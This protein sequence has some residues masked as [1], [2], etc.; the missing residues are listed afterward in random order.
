METIIVREGGLDTEPQVSKDE[1]KQILLDEDFMSN[2]YKFALS[3]FFLEPDHK[4]TCKYISEK[5]HVSPSSLN[6]LITQFSAKVE[7]K[8]NRFKIVKED[9]A[10]NWWPITMTGRRLSGGLFEWKLRQELVDAMLELDYI[11]SNAITI[12]NL[13]S[14]VELL[15]IDLRE[16]INTFRKTRKVLSDKER[17]TSAGILFKVSD[18]QADWAINESEHNEIQY[19]LFLKDNQIGY[20]LGFNAQYVPSSNEKNSLELVKPFIDAFLSLQDSEEVK[21]LKD[22]GFEVDLTALKNMRDGQYILFGRVVSLI[23]DK[24]SLIDYYSIVNDLKGDLFNAYKKVF[25][26]ANKIRFIKEETSQMVAQNP[27]VKEICEL[28]ETNKNIILTGAP[29]TGKTYLAKEV[30]KAFDAASEFVQFHPSYDYTDFV[31]GLR[32]TQ[33]DKGTV[34]FELRDGIFKAFCKEAVKY[35]KNQ[36]LSNFDEVY[37]RFIDDVSENGLELVTPHH[38]KPFNITTN[39][40]DSVV[41]TPNTEKQT[42]MTVTKDY[43]QTYFETGKVIDWKP[44]LIPICEYIKANYELIL[45]SIVN[46]DKKFVIILDEINRAEV[47]KVLGELFYS[48]DPGYRGETGRVKTQYANLQTEGDVFKSGFYVPDN[49]Y[50]I[51]TMNDIDRSVESFDF[52]MRRRFAWKEIKAADRL[53]MW[54]GVI[55]P[56]IKESTRRLRALNAAIESIE[57]LNSAYH[58]GPAY[59][60]KLASYEGDFEA[61]WQHHLQSL[62]FEYVRG[63]PNADQQL[64]IMKTAYD[65]AA[66]DD[67]NDG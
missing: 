10:P 29:G 12:K 16:F 22:R 2:N 24:L 43:I 63:Y 53:S 65:R 20:G 67:S 32:P 46:K 37:Q 27:L 17:A 41:A 48:I 4:A 7:G 33:N 59:F 60:L 66:I 57:G 9:G 62:L 44:Y 1:W 21:T 39:S 13:A 30:V 34:G 45:P 23:D 35:Q 42:S 15:N 3:A 5:Y 26:T 8:L 51:G 56:W 11:A 6:G 55:D 14:L 54:D 52:A 18:D 64:T 19:H 28:L 31:E 49:V 38:K 50:I 47:S 58:V 36:K 40:K 25:E 61:L